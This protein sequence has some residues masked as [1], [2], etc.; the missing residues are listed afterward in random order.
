MIFFFFFFGLLNWFMICNFCDAVQHVPF[1]QLLQASLLP[2]DLQV[3]YMWYLG[4]YHTRWGHPTQSSRESWKLETKSDGNPEG[5]GF[6]L[7]QVA[8]F[9]HE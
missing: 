1:K 5:L 7:M 3:N 4:E 2:G 6:F 8:K 9:I